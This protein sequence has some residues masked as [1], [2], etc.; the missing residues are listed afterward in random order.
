MLLGTSESWVLD[1]PWVYVGFFAGKYIGALPVLQAR[2]RKF[3]LY[4]ELIRSCVYINEILHLSYCPLLLKLQIE[5]AS[6]S[7][8]GCIGIEPLYV[9]R[10]FM[11]FSLLFEQSGA[12]IFMSSNL[13]CKSSYTDR[14]KYLLM[15]HT[16]RA[17]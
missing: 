17:I 7:A 4:A 5:S 15:D 13:V 6:L 16:V 3:D 10:N 11:Q 12:H 1:W 8:K 14:V 2:A 9:F